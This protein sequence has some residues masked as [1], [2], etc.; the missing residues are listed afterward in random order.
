[1]NKPVVRCRCGHQILAKEVLRTDLYER[2]APEGNTR[3][4][5]YVKYRCQ[6]CKRIGEAFV[7]E[8]RWD[9]SIL[10]PEHT[11]LTEAERE[12]FQDISPISSEEILD[13]H[14]ELERTGLY[15]PPEPQTPSVGHSPPAED[16]STQVASEQSSEAKNSDEKSAEAQLADAKSAEHKSDKKRTPPRRLFRR[17][18]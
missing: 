11:E 3:E 4:F 18:S 10:E 8:S 14:C 17:D 12:H 7:P 6:H 16:M 15:T 5:V 2:R 1:M 9:R 13:F